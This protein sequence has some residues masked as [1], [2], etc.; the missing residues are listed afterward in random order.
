MTLKEIFK[1]VSLQSGDHIKNQMIFS[2]YYGGYGFFGGLET[3]STNEMYSVKVS[4]PTTVTV[5]GT[6]TALPK[7]ITLDRGWTFVPCPH[8]TEVDLNAGKP[9]FAFSAKDQF[10]SQMEFAE[11]YDGYG[12]YGTLT[13]LT[14]GLGYKV[15]VAAGGEAVFQS[16]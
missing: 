1:D 5:T 9:T 6:P 15:R 2:D 10:K 13:K 16:V 14:P 11:Y 8:Q 4:A 3:L 12:F 7:T